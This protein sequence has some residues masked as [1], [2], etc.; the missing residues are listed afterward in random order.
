MHVRGADE[1]PMGAAALQTPPMRSIS[2]STP[3]GHYLTLILPQLLPSPRSPI[4]I[5][6]LNSIN[7]NLTP[8][9]S[10]PTPAATYRGR[11]PA[12]ALDYATAACLAGAGAA[13]KRFLYGSAAGRA[14]YLDTGDGDGDGDEGKGRA[15]SGRGPSGRPR[16][17]G[18]TYH[19]SSEPHEMM[20]P[21]GRTR[22]PLPEPLR[23][24][25]SSHPSCHPASLQCNVVLSTCN[26]VEFV[27]DNG[28]G[29]VVRAGVKD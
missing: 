5:P 15:C 4:F 3:P 23:R 1:G 10:L 19:P 29:A 13:F 6:N 21:R 20:M 12:D 28:I 2:H 22:G 9:P 17:T 11:A 27:L 7:P 16:G 26:Q 8:V 18:H 25:S 24:A 14:L